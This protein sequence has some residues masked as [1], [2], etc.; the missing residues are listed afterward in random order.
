[1]KILVEESGISLF[2]GV[3]YAEFTKG[4]IIRIAETEGAKYQYFE[5]EAVIEASDLSISDLI[6]KIRLLKKDPQLFVSPHKLKTLTNLLDWVFRHK[7]PKSYQTMLKVLKQVLVKG[8][9]PILA[10]ETLEARKIM[11]WSQD[12]QNEVRLNIF[13]L[14]F[15][16]VS[17]QGKLFRARCSLKHKTYDVILQ[18][19][20]KIYPDYNFLLMMK[21]KS[22]I[23]NRF[24]FKVFSNCKKKGPLLKRQKNIYSLLKKV[25]RTYLALD[26]I[27]FVSETSKMKYNKTTNYVDFYNKIKKGELKV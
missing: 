5:A 14:K 7:D 8:C 10:G 21:N 13:K 19:W 3:L 23:G 22:V 15:S 1:M 16:P 9:D 12:V 18:Q 24:G 27:N 6:T 20:I 11:R 25:Q 2:K 4:E 17:D 26:H